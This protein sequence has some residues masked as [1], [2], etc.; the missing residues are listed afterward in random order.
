MKICAWS[1]GARQFEAGLS[2]TKNLDPPRQSTSS[3]M[4]TSTF[5]SVT[6]FS[7]F[8]DCNNDM[9]KVP[10]FRRVLFVKIQASTNRWKF[11]AG[12]VRCRRMH[13][14][15]SIVLFLCPDSSRALRV[16]KTGV[17]EHVC[18]HACLLWHFTVAY[19]LGLSYSCVRRLHSSGKKR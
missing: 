11:S 9:Q 5:F 14:R 17:T 8:L 6:A 7:F 18:P 4:I 13:A 1:P 3:E 12:Y 16:K 19:S 10:F 15:L 2:R